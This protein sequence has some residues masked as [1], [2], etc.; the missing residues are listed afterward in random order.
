MLASLPIEICLQLHAPGQDSA[1]TLLFPHTD[2][3][4]RVRIYV[5]KS[6]SKALELFH[7]TCLKKCYTRDNL[8]ILI[9]VK[10]KTDTLKVNQCV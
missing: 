10:I 4:V 5:L 2:K 1:S 8:V 3:M 9:I 7:V 6:K